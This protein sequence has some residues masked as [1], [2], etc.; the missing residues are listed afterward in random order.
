MEIVMHIVKICYEVLFITRVVFIKKL[1]YCAYF[2]CYFSC[3]FFMKLEL[4]LSFG[5]YNGLVC[6]IP[7][8]WNER[9]WSYYCITRTILLSTYTWWVSFWRPKV[10]M[11][12]RS[13]TLS[14]VLKFCQPWKL[15]L[16]RIEREWTSFFS[17]PIN[18]AISKVMK[19]L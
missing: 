14:L 9:V 8:W 2:T 18:N 5:A 10:L 1:K 16:V 11:L 12:R 3:L 7:Y 17:F 6:C 15:L 13:I 19:K 4:S